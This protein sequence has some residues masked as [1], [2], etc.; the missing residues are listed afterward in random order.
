M[1]S[2]Y[3]FGTVPLSRIYELGKKN[4]LSPLPWVSLELFYL[5]IALQQQYSSKF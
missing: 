4:I 3:H 5:D 1:Y 2:V